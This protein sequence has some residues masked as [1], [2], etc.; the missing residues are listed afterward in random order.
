[1]Q[2][3]VVKR[4][5]SPTKKAM[6]AS[7]LN[8]CLNHNFD[9]T[10][11]IYEIFY[12]IAAISMI[13]L[14]YSYINAYSKKL[15]KASKHLFHLANLFYVMVFIIYILQSIPFALYCHHPYIL[16][17]IFQ[18]RFAVYSFSNLV[19]FVIF[20]ERLTLIFRDTQLAV[21]VFTKRLFYGL[22]WLGIFILVN[23]TTFHTISK[24]PNI[25]LLSA[26]S[27][28]VIHIFLVIW[29]NCLFIN[30]L[31]KLCELDDKK[32]A[33]LVDIITKTAFF[34]FISTLSTVVHLGIYFLSYYFG[35]TA[36]N[37]NLFRGF[38]AFL[39]MET[40]FLSVFLVHRY[41]NQWYYK[42]CGCCHRKCQRFY[43]SKLLNNLVQHTKDQQ[44]VDITTVNNGEGN[45]KQNRID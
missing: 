6:S 41:Y 1:M 37:V 10:F 39:D 21:S 36:N 5:S 3:S 12:G 17:S 9:Y 27:G 23:S 45:S 30:K 13:P 38:M 4:Q 25:Y 20:F 11:Y 24:Y 29:L 22:W 7:D 14:V 40:N 15:L 34:T 33:D 16:Y 44:V 28:A 42:L 2:V 32:N 31:S 18:V 35:W 8:W 43:N 19:L 26:L